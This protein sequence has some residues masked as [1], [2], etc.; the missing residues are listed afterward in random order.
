MDCSVLL[1]H[2]ITIARE[3]ADFISAERKRF[4][5]SKVEVKGLH[6]LV[7]YVDRGA[8]QLIVSRLR[9]ALPGS[10]F[11]TEENT[12]TNRAEY[13][14]I[15]DP[16]DGTT[17]FIHGLTCYAVS[18]A[19]EHESEILLGVVLEVSRS[20]CFSAVKGG[21]AFLNG[22]KIQI[23][24]RSMLHESL[25]GTG[26]PVYDFSRMA[27]FLNSLRFFMENTRGVRRIG[28]AAADLCFVACGRLDAFYEYNL[29]PWDVAAGALIAQEAGARVGDFSG[30]SNWL[31]GKEIVCAGRNL[32]PSF[33]ASVQ[34]LFGA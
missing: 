28:A 6:D 24:G 25:V 18:I 31:F 17:N 27:P 1:P 11:I 3:A 26:F 21:G 20:E 23:S 9:D 15:I 16:L 29:K 14:W 8:E 2:V 7:S 22:N 13:N 4:N 5:E 32:Y 30:G 34:K 33:S 10:G 19:L 12:A